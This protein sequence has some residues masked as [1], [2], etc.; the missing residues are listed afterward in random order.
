MLRGPRQCY[1]DI[2][3]ATCWQTMRKRF[4]SQQYVPD[5][6][7]K[8]SLCVPLHYYT[9][10]TLLAKCTIARLIY[11]L[12]SRYRTITLRSRDSHPAWQFL[13][14]RRGDRSLGTTQYIVTP[15]QRQSYENVVLSAM[16]AGPQSPHIAIQRLGCRIR[17]PQRRG[18]KKKNFQKI[19]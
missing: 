1:R 16:T 18:L 12:A 5:F 3:P 11:L 13:S 7:S 4:Y 2:Y 9:K 15:G 17:R 19:V 14:N 6:V 10:F 8:S